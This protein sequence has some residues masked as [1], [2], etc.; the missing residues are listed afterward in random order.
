MAETQLVQMDLQLEQELLK[1]LLSY[2]ARH[3]G[4]FR[5]VYIGLGLL[6]RNDTRRI[7][8]EA[9]TSYGHRV[10]NLEYLLLRELLTAVTSYD[11]STMVAVTYIPWYEP[12]CK[13]KDVCLRLLRRY[14]NPSSY[15]FRMTLTKKCV[16]QNMH[17]QMHMHTYFEF[18][19]DDIKMFPIYQIVEANQSLSYDS[20][21]NNCSIKAFWRSFE[22]GKIM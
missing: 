6:E 17:S 13:N 1:G 10:N 15:I 3:K 11:E 16:E 8:T 22:S 20:S 9:I 18:F 14:I 2:V 7:V 5:T 21:I 19:D 12:H 4:Q